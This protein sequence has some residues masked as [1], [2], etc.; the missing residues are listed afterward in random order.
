MRIFILVSLLSVAVTLVA[1]DNKPESSPPPK[2]PSAAASGTE[3]KD[4]HA[5]KPGEKDDH[6]HSKDGKKE[7]DA[8]GGPVIELGTATAGGMSI[9]ASRDAGELKPGGDAPIDVWIDG[10]LGN[11]A[12]VRFWIGMEDAKGSIKAKAEVE[13]GKWHTHAELPDPLPA[14]SKLW[15]EIEGKDGKR[16]VASFDL[17]K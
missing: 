5:H 14:A 12:A 2:P 16:T 1:C 9:R 11:A 4:D 10:G 13:A 8:H 17:K 3:K 6:D 7:G 15:V